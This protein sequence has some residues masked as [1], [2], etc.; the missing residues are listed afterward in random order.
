MQPEEDFVSV[1]NKNRIRNDLKRSQGSWKRNCLRFAIPPTQLWTPERLLFDIGYSLFVSF[2]CC[3][4]FVIFYLLF[5]GAK[6]QKMLT[7]V[8]SE[9]A[10]A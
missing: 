4:L 10:K 9:G 2:I 3:L 6:I 1:L 7:S 8:L 5:E